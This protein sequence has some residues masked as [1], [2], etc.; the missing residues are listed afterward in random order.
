MQRQFD[1]LNIS[2]VRLTGILGEAVPEV[3]RPNF[4]APDGSGFTHLKRGEIGCYASHLLACQKIAAGEFGEAAIVFEDDV[5]IADDLRAAVHNAMQHL[6]AGWDIVRLSN[7]AKR[8]Y[9]PLADVGHERRL[10]RY[11]VIPNSAAAYLVSVRGARKIL[12]PRRRTRSF[13]EDLRA[14]YE[15][16][17]QSFGIVPPPVRPDVLTST[18]DAL[19]PG[20]LPQGLKKAGRR[21]ARWTPRSTIERIA[22]NCRTLGTGRWVACLAMNQ[23]DRMARR[24]GKPSILPKATRWLYKPSKPVR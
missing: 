17:L 10:V 24:L 14:A 5:E 21:L 11:S 12:G 9:V 1:R 16:D 6:P 20:R 23:A 22:F 19:E 7:A 18:I 8:A 3:L 2:F 13:D 4:Y 15:T